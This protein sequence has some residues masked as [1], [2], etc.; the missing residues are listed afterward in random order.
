V[1]VIE[2]EYEDG[3]LRLSKPLHLRQGERVEVIVKRRPDPSRW[4]LERLARSSRTEDEQLSRA[5]LD[6]WEHVLKDEDEH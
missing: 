1:A 5:G 6:R 4:D 2:A 3:V